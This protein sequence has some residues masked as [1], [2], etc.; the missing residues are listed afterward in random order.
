M[1][2]NNNEDK[3]VKTKFKP[4]FI[5]IYVILIISFFVF[6]EIL[7]RIFNYGLDFSPFLKHKTLEKYYFTNSSYTNKY[8]PPEK[9]VF[10]E[11]DDEEYKGC[12]LFLRKKPDNIVRGFVVGGSTAQG[13]PYSS[14]H[15]FGKMIESSLNYSQ[16]KYKFEI[17]NL[18]FIAMSSY[19]VYDTMKNLKKYEPDFFIIYSGHNEY[20]G[21]I[22]ATTSK[23]HIFRKLYIFLRNFKVVQLIQNISVKIGKKQLNE[24]KALM[25]EQFAGNKLKKNEKLDN[26]VAKCFIKNIEDSIKLY[27][28]KN[29][30]IFLVEPVS[31]FIDMPPFTSKDED[32]YSDL[33]TE[34]NNAIEKKDLNSIVA[35][36]N[37]I[38]SELFNK[39]AHFK[40]LQAKKENI[41]NNNIDLEKYVDAKDLDMIPFRARSNINNEL[42]ELSEKNKYRNL[43]Y[44]PLLDIIK[45]N[46]NSYFNNTIFIDHLHFNRNGQKL[47]AKTITEKILSMNDGIINSSL[48]NNMRRFYA[49]D[50]FLENSIYYFPPY[51]DIS[52]FFTINRLSEGSPYKDMKIKY[53]ENPFPINEITK[54][55]ILLEKLNNDKTKKNILT[56]VVS[57][58]TDEKKTYSLIDLFFSIL[59]TEPL[60]HEVCYNLSYLYESI[61][62]DEMA[63]YYLIYGYLVSN[64]NK[65]MTNDLEAFYKRIGTPEKMDEIK[66]LRDFP[67]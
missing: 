6:L 28:K 47:I 38:D 14:N 15:S 12:N 58:Y 29:I 4:I 45:D 31:N 61:E 36:E 52:A 64:K 1:D 40:Y 22:S 51:N 41:I 26:Y 60:N 10:L 16:N 49:N 67:E 33:I 65:Q 48:K 17:L 25:E 9:N 37:K 46:Y 30:P 13:F 5:L 43:Y 42:K 39:N 66:K 7:L 19:Y 27:Y 55:E 32:K 3:N 56:T 62:E 11:K 57:K 2:E 35:I 44:I 63:E 59:Y 20:Y 34:Y 23:F 8:Y 50:K 54:N 18:S 24:N 53:E 21:S